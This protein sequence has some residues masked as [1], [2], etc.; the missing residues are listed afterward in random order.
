MVVDQ[1]RVIKDRPIGQGG[2]DHK[3]AIELMATLDWGGY[4]SGEWIDWEPYGEVLPR[5]LATMKAY[6]AGL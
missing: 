2:I 3:R 6:E 5:E 1:G 4:F